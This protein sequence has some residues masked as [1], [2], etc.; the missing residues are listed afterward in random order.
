MA[1]AWVK[2][3][4]ARVNPGLVRLKFKRQVPVVRWASTASGAKGFGAPRFYGCLVCHRWS[5]F[6][7]ISP[8]IRV[9]LSLFMPLAVELF[10]EHAKRIE[11]GQRFSIGHV[12]AVPA[13]Q[14]RD[15]GNT[16]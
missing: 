5:Y 6:Q 7:P 15:F 1:A 12:L 10:F 3:G 14:K 8:G 13:D 2:R 16:Q 4:G 9:R 11:L